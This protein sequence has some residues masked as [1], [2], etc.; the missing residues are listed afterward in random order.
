[1]NKSALQDARAVS[2][3][4]K[5]PCW[6][7]TTMGRCVG[8]LVSCLLGTARAQG[9]SGGDE[10]SFSADGITGLA[11]GADAQGTGVTHAEIFNGLNWATATAGVCGSGITLTSLMVR[12]GSNT[13]TAQLPIGT[14]KFTAYQADS[15]KFEDCVL[16]VEVIDQH[17]P[18][19]RCPA[20]QIAQVQRSSGG[21]GLTTTVQG[22]A[23]FTFSTPQA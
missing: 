7:A 10:I 19:L 2:V 12:D 18:R 16:Q 17:A 15:T 4:G 5:I 8:V 23:L 1:M 3:K 13:G 14:S 11:Q 20:R 22:E 9:C 21:T 6:S